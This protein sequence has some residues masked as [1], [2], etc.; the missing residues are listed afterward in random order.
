VTARSDRGQASVEL[1]GALP[2]LIVLGLVLLQLLSVGYAAVLAGHA[3]EAGALAA[4]AGGAP[5]QAARSA[6]P[7][8]AHAR[9][10]V[11]ERDGRVEVTL[12]PPW[13]LRAVSRRLEVRADATVAFQ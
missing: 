3:A 12:R 4:A 5:E 13:P 1:L 2:A 11:A 8:W 6:L 9:M 7:G 10:R